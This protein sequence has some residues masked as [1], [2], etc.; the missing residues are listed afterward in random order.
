MSLTWSSC[1]LDG[2][3]SVIEEVAADT[4]QSTASVGK[5]FLLC[6][7]A[8]RIVD[9]RLDP[10]V[11][12]RRDPAA[13][14]GDSGLWQHLAQEELPL[15]DVCVLVGAVSDNWATNALLQFVGLDAVAARAGL[16]DCARSGL[17]D[18][19]RD[20]RSD[21]DPPKLSSGTARELAE[22]ARRIY[23]AATGR[24]VS[25]I[26][27]GAA[28]LVENWLMC[29][30]DLSM[31]PAP[32]HLDPLARVDGPIRV[33]SK[34]GTDAGVRAD[35]GVIWSDRGAVAYAAVANWDPREDRVVE[36][37]Q[38]MHQLGAGIAARMW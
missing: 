31:V 30:V 32:L 8:E 16:L 22:T 37:M 10:A 13:R 18:R 12:V 17:H 6:E 21:N 14:V 2:H 23:L 24:V 1:L 3:G 11:P 38:H 19:V 34:T 7:V 25:G 36:A 20:E 27:G 26:S 28:E 4:V 9:G 29:G 15:A 5:V 33:W 35:M